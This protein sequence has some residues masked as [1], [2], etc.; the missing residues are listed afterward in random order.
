MGDFSTI[1]LNW[2]PVHFFTVTQKKS[3]VLLVTL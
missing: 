1:M 3:Y 2:K